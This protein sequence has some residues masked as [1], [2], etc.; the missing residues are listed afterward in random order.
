[1]FAQEPQQMALVTIIKRAKARLCGT[2]IGFGFEMLR[3]LII[4]AGISVKDK[5][6]SQSAALL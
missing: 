1:V 2:N 3:A 6:K 4:T 5:P